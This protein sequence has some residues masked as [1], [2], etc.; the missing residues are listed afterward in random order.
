[1]LALLCKACCFVLNDHAAYQIIIIINNLIKFLFKH[2]FDSL[3][4]IISYVII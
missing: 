3:N 2:I 4:R 1:M